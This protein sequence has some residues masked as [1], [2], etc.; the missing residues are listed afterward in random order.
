MPVVFVDKLEALDI[1]CSDFIFSRFNVEP[2][3]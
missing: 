1:S 3:S 2:Q